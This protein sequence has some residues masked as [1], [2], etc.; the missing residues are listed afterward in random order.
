MDHPCIPRLKT[1]HGQANTTTYKS[2]R[3]DETRRTPPAPANESKGTRGEKKLHGSG[4]QQAAADRWIET[5][6][7][8]QQ[9]RVARALS[10]SSSSRRRK[11]TKSGTT[12]SHPISSERWELGAPLLQVHGAAVLGHD[13]RHVHRVVAPR[14]P[15]PPELHHR[16][17]QRH[18][19]H[20]VVQRVPLPHALVRPGAERQEV[21]LVRHVLPPG[22]REEA[23]RVE[24]LR[25]REPLERR[26]VH[27]RE[28]DG[29]LGHRVP[30]RQRE[31]LARDVRHQRR[32]GPVA[33]HLPRHRLRVPH[34]LD[35]LRRHRL[36][37]IRGPGRRH[38]R[39]HAGQHL[40]V[41][42]QRR[43]RPAQR[44]RRRVLRREQEVEHE[45]A[46]LLVRG[47]RRRGAARRRGLVHLPQRVLH[48]VV[49]EALGLA[50]R[51]HA[52]LALPRALPE[53]AHQPRHALPRATERE[54]GEVHGQR[55]QPHVE[56]V[57]VALEPAPRLRAQVR[58]R[59]HR[60]RR[61]QVHVAAGHADGERPRGA[62]VVQPP[63]EVRQDHALLERRVGGQRARGEVGRDPP[64]Q[65]LVV[66]AEH[67]DEVVLPEELLAEGVADEVERVGADVGEHALRQLRVA[68]EHHE[69]PH[70][71]VR[72]QARPGQ[73]GARRL[74]VPERRRV[75]DHVGDAA[76]ERHHER[77][78]GEGALLAVVRQL[79]HQ[80]VERHRRH[81][82]RRRRAEVQE[83]GHR[84]R[85]RHCSPTHC[86]RL[87]DNETRPWSSGSRRR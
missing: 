17:E 58:A 32:G 34:P 26:L 70:Q 87:A 12:S 1:R 79:L 75:A 54:P 57:V 8:W 84:L 55:H 4:T 42:V 39:A 71:E 25:L 47:V 5:R 65:V 72:G 6:K 20:Q 13:G 69:P 44:R 63:P 50:A 77:G 78:A 67:V 27:G 16:H 40:R 33:D 28:H 24:R 52:R 64:P 51:A 29:A 15:L 22:L 10:S 56:E 73:L 61:L 23:L 83:T 76:E 18:E 62:P 2:S 3:R 14:R 30:L 49:H 38:L 46:D 68:D 21:A 45:P 36:A 9:K 48:P 86:K 85:R 59:E 60:L 43:H 31:R 82:E 53:R 66:L 80:H 41:G 19:Q 11:M 35:R 37:G 7:T 74:R 81:Q